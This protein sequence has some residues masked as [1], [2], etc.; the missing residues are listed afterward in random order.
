M[1]AFP[2]V[3]FAGR[4]TS[5]AE[6]TVPI[7]SVALRYGV[8]VFEGIRLYTPARRDNP[9]PRPFLLAEHVARLR[10][11]LALLGMS[12][13]GVSQLPE[14]LDE[15]IERNAIM[16]DAY[17]RV[18]ATPIEPGDL[19][20]EIDPVLSVTAAPMGRKRWLAEGVGMSLTIS[21]WQRAGP[22][23]FPPA[24]KNIS[25]YAGPRLAWLAAQRAGF[26]GCVLTNRAGRLCEAPTAALFLVKDG[27]LLTPALSEDVLPSITR[28]W[29]LRRAA[30]LG[31]P[32][33]E[34][35]LTRED[36]Y[37]ADEAFLCGTGMEI[38]SIRAF[39]GH[40]LSHGESAPVTREIT[41]Y[42]FI[43][44]RSADDRLATPDLTGRL[45]G[46]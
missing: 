37:T 5:R 7:G 41:T 9:P 43:A 20:D 6:A 29:I 18:A 39:D 33:R 14:L 23:V 31:L 25:N 28:G 38:A 8:S 17:V 46:R 30:E 2:H 26:D 12:D 13:P 16:Q 45:V 15:L 10:N 24:A 21:D 35:E 1:S 19:A 42:Y 22:A 40:E 44:A 11:S 34:A 32:S 36:A 3:Y 27:V 4:W